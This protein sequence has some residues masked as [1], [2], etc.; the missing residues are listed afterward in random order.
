[1]GALTVY[2]MQNG[3]PIKII[4][5]FDSVGN[6]CGQ[7]NQGTLKVDFTE[8]KYKH[9]TA[10]IPNLAPDAVCVKEC[11]LQKQRPICIPN[12]DVTDC[13]ESY[14]DTEIL[15]TYCVP[16]KETAIEAGKKILEEMNKKAD[17]STYLADVAK[18]WQAV[19]GMAGATIIISLVYIVLL[20][21]ITKPL[22]Y[23]SM[24][25]ILIMFILLG[26]FAYL[27]A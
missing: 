11:P 24:L 13:P 16:S 25:L 19:A 12:K 7:P 23:I 21:W 1:M 27:K 20:R 18:C 22:L 10:I 17:F 5:P 4:T 15:F 6:E 3:D 26:G 8:F 14:Y 2:G 9:F